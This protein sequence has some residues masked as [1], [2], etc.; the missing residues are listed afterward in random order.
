[1]FLEQT[2][3]V[4]VQIM[5]VEQLEA[6]MRATAAAKARAA[7][8]CAEKKAFALQLA[9]LRQPTAAAEATAAAEW[10]ERNS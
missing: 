4:V 6:L 10:A 1:M 9:S 2:H 5:V 8:E 7:A 3:P